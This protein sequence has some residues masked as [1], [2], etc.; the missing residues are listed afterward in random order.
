MVPKLLEIY[1][2]ED[3]LKLPLRKHIQWWDAVTQDDEDHSISK[4]DFS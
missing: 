2:V 4:A 3:H 1:I